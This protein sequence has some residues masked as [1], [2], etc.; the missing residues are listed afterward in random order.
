MTVSFGLIVIHVLYLYFPGCVVSSNF[1]TSFKRRKKRACERLHMGTTEVRQ[2]QPG[3]HDAAALSNGSC[4]GET[5][6]L[7]RWDGRRPP[8]LLGQHFSHVRLSK[9]SAF[10]TSAL[11]TFSMLGV[12]T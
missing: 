5:T 1:G 10:V 6:L 11:G 2:M 9:V 4:K 3:S 12:L 7:G 8:P